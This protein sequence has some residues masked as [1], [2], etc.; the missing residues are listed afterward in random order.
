MTPG[1]SI[2]LTY[3]TI[4]SISTDL[5]LLGPETDLYAS[6][7]RQKVIGQDTRALLPRPEEEDGVVVH[8]RFK[9]IDFLVCLFQR[10]SCGF[11]HRFVFALVA[12]A[13]ASVERQY[14]MRTR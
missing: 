6:T 13:D 12:V 9:I 4:F 5:Q 3:L 10:F 1:T 11:Y 2:C 7:G 14:C 8:K